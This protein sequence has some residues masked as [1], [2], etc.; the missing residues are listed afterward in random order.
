MS[1]C[2]VLA[3]KFNEPLWR[4]EI[5]PLRDVLADIERV[6][7]LSPKVVLKEELARRLV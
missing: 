3:Y 6:Q 7:N 4:T 2:L 1:V 5:T